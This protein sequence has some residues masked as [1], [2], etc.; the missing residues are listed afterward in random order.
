VSWTEYTKS[1]PNIWWEVTY[2]VTNEDDEAHNYIMW[3]KWG[4]NLLI[5][6]SEP[7]GFTGYDKKNQ[8]GTLA[9]ANG[10]PFEIDYAG[11]SGYVDSRLYFDTAPYA[12]TQGTAYATLH[13]GDQQEGTN[14]GKGR[15]SNGKDG[16]A[17]DVDIRWEIGELGPGETATLTIILAPGI[18]PGGILQFSS[19]G[20]YIVNTGPRVRVYEDGDYA[21]DEFLYSWDWTNQLKIC[22]QPTEPTPPPSPPPIIYDSIAINPL[23]VN[24]I[25]L[26]VLVMFLFI[27]QL[28][29]N[30]VA[31]LR[32][33]ITYKTVPI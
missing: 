4:G 20:C 11:Y 16:Q 21:D 14:P 2:S 6:N 25:I 24:V 1:G 12:P 3:D 17:Y 28:K 30:I 5:L 27:A 18:N 22:V 26:A 15:G 9:L 19:Y 13:S 32:K 29:H 33:T 31:K 7:T 8:P 10:E 23:A